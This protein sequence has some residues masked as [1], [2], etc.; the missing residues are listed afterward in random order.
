MPR[1]EEEASA[2]PP[3]CSSGALV[4][5]VKHQHQLVAEVTVPAPAA[6]AAPGH[7]RTK[8]MNIQTRRYVGGAW[9]R[10]PQSLREAFGSVWGKLEGYR[11][12][13][14]IVGPLC[15]GRGERRGE[16][17]EGKEIYHDNGVLQYRIEVTGEAR[18]VM[19]GVAVRL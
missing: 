2:P 17:A 15:L 1:K 6:A 16:K 9:Q 3:W 13:T 19:N 7:S 12:P 10:G 14:C 18:E 11:R 5:K 8:K 4:A